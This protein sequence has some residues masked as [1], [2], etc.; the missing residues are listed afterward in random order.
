MALRIVVDTN[1]LISAL[2]SR[3]GASYK[4]LSLIDSPKLE[5][6]LSVPLVLEYEST[7]KR[8]SNTL[9]QMKTLTPL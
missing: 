9:G 8:I 2:R 3:Q 4:L 1:V 6:C 5:I 7:A